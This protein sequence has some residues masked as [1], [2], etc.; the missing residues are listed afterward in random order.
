MSEALLDV[1]NTK[2]INLKARPP[3]EGWLRSVDVPTLGTAT[4]INAGL[5]IVDATIAYK[6]A[7]IVLGGSGEV[8]YC[9]QPERQSIGYQ[10]TA[11]LRD[12]DALR[13]YLIP[14]QSE[15]IKMALPER[16]PTALESR[17]VT[18]TVSPEVAR[19]LRESRGQPHPFRPIDP[20]VDLW[21]AALEET[22]EG[23]VD[24]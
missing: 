5:V 24:E 19:E 12:P 6:P 13:R 20:F 2:P 16:E 18:V 11:T 21:L 22:P 9:P 14:V 10:G 23:Q 1:P 7:V 17:P 8:Q 3:Q 15:E 4:G